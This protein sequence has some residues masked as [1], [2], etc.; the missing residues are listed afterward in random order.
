MITIA[1]LYLYDI[2]LIVVSE[3]ASGSPAWMHFTLQGPVGRQ[4]CQGVLLIRLLRVGTCGATDP[5]PYHL[6]SNILFTSEYFIPELTA[7]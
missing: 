2:D 5:I 4:T 6:I 7:S 1:R 3:W